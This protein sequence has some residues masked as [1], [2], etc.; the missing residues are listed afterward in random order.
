MEY[1]DGTT[2]V[3]FEYTLS[4]NDGPAFDEVAEILAFIQGNYTDKSSA[5]T[6]DANNDPA[7]NVMLQTVEEIAASTGGNYGQY[8][9]DADNKSALAAIKEVEDKIN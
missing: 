3:P 6:L 1:A 2:S 4:A 8:T 7:E 5:Y 9:L